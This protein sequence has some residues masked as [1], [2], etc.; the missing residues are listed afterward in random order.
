MKKLLPIFALLVLFFAPALHVH[1]Q[2][3]NPT[4]VV[5]KAKV[6]QVLSSK[7][8]IIAGTTTSEPVQKLQALILDGVDQGQTVT[9]ENDFPSQLQA[10]EEFYVT[11][12]VDPSDNSVSYGYLDPNRLPAMGI[13]IGLLVL[14]VFMFGGKQGIRGLLSLVGSIAFIVYVLLP[15]VLHGY[16]PVLVSMGVASLIIVIGSY[17]THGFSKTTSSAV[18]GM[19]VTILLTG[20]L[21]FASIHY[22]HLTGFASEE[23]TYLNV[24]ENLHLDFAGLLL[25]GILIGLLG[26]LY[27]AAIGQAVSVDELRQVGPHLSRVAIYRR[28]IRIGR[29]HIG[30]LM[31]TLAIAYVGASLPLLLLFYDTSQISPWLVIN[32]E[33]FATEIVRI[34]IG[35]IGLVLAVP[36]TTVI[37]TLILVHKKTGTKEVMLEEEKKLEHF[38]HKH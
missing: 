29:E 31:N 37:A 9:I 3:A 11:R 2:D 28:A 33:I 24:S 36:I 22:V 16:S 15:S 19:I 30:A 32:K 4:P 17:V 35:S 5:E 27:D 25:G 7:S 38:E 18:L 23:S 20:A 13:L 8:V 26:V 1:A 34:V 14:L 12:N 6:I 21:A 10:G